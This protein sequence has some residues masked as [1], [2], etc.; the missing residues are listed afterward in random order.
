VTG[1]PNDRVAA[2][3]EAARLLS[4]ERGLGT[5]VDVR[6]AIASAAVGGVDPEDVWQLGDDVG[7]ATTLSWLASHE[8]GAFDAGFVRIDASAVNGKASAFTF[9]TSARVPHDV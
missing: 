7:C 8:H 2:D 4:S 1:I 5:A 9:P 6:R 3:V